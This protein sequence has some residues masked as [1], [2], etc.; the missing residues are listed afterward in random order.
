MKKTDRKK[1]VGAGLY[2]ALAACVLSAMTINVVS[3]FKNKDT[4]NEDF[5]AVDLKAEG[6]TDTSNDN[7]DVKVEIKNDTPTTTIPP[8][9]QE[10]VT[11]KTEA[12]ENSA[13]Q[14][15]PNQNTENFPTANENKTDETKNDETKTDETKNENH[16]NSSTAYQEF[17]KPV[18]GEFGNYNGDTFV[19]SEAF[20]DYRIHEGIDIKANLGASVMSFADGTIT[21]VYDHAL[22]GKTIVIDH[23]DGL[24]SVYKNL[25]VEMPEGITAGASVKAGDVIGS[26]GDSSI[27]KCCNSPHLHFEVCYNEESVDPTQY[28]SE[29]G[30]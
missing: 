8:I 28:F 5:S 12:I 16:T 3:S 2:I 30:K 7:T 11:G 20:G 29:T 1:F 23:G 14:N 21:Q 24:V 17:V 15:T 27:A 9:K 18:V 26:V 4:V 6:V 10:I 13:L 19:Y 25:A 22:M